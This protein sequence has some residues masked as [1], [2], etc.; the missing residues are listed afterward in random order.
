M[1]SCYDTI[2]LNSFLSKPIT[3]NVIVFLVINVLLRFSNTIEN[4]DQ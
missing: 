1:L 3:L 4:H 2:Q